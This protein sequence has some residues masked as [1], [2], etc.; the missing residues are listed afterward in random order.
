MSNSATPTDTSTDADIF[1]STDKGDL[2]EGSDQAKYA[3]TAKVKGAVVRPSVKFHD[4]VGTENF[5]VE[6]RRYRLYLAEACPWSHRTYMVWKL[7]GLEEV[8][9]LTLTG[10]KLENISFKPP[11]T[12]YHGWDFD[13]SEGDGITPNYYKEPNGFSH[14]EQVYELAH[15]GFRESYESKCQRPYYSAPVLF[16]E[17]TKKIVSTESAD[18]VRMFNTEFNDVGANALDLCPK[19]LESKMEKADR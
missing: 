12:N 15:P 8:V 4:K 14:I 6:K 19:D 5:P 7:K 17:K 1:W 10:W 11:F 16:D 2:T 13:E 9:P 18:I 3:N